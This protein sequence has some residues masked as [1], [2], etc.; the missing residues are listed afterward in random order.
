MQKL[1]KERN[2]ADFMEAKSFCKEVMA[3]ITET[4]P[5]QHLSRL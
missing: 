1:T 5:L 2:H 4:N 3:E